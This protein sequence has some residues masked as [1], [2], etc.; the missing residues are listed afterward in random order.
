M[1]CDDCGEKA[2]IIPGEFHQFCKKCTERRGSALKTR[3]GKQ[4]PE[5]K[6]GIFFDNAV[7]I[8]I[9]K[10]LKKTGLFFPLQRLIARSGM[11]ND[12]RNRDLR[13]FISVHNPVIVEVGANDGTDTLRF[14]KIFPDAKVYSFEPDPRAAKAF[15]RRHRGDSRIKLFEMAVG[16]HNGT[17]KFYLSNLKPGQETVGAQEYTFSSTLKKPDPRKWQVW[18]ESSKWLEWNQHIKVPVTTLDTWSKKS[19]ITHID[20]LWIDVEHAELEVIKGAKQILAHTTYCYVE[21]PEYDEKATAALI[22]SLHE[23]SWKKKYGNNALFERKH[24]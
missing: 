12:I 19:G 15:R 4:I 10:I 8:P 17:A 20:F 21:Y 9:K 5:V 7:T 14:V 24:T 22:K 13:H 3:K 6:K 2:T 1:E 23:F 16:E 18:Q 11:L